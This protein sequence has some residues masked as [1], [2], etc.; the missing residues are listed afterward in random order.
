[1]N[2]LIVRT[3]QTEVGETETPRVSKIGVIMVTEWLANFLSAFN[4]APILPKCFPFADLADPRKVA[5]RS[6]RC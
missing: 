3:A 5:D 4:T 1:M 2:L 6:L